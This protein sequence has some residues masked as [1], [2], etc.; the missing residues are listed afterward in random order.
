MEKYTI[1][2]TEDSSKYIDIYNKIKE[3][4]ECKE[5]LDGEKLPTIRI[6]SKYLKVNKITVINAY[7]KLSTEGYIYQVQG[8]GSYARR[9]EAVKNLKNEYKDI[10]NKIASG[11]LKD[12]IDFTGETTSTNFFKVETLREV[13]NEVLTRDGIDALTYND[14]LG[15]KSLRESINNNFWNGKNCLDNML[16]ISG[17]QQGIDIV[18]KALINI[19]E[20]VIVEKPTYSGALTV[21][22][23]RGANVLQVPIENDG[24]NIEYLEKLIK[25]YKVKCFYTM[26]Y[27]QNPTGVS[28]S[29][30]KKKKIIEL[31][32]KYNFYIIEDDYLS[33]LIYDDEIEYL[34]YRSLDSKRVI[35]IKSFSKI[36]LPGIRIGYLLAPTEFNEILHAS[37]VSTDISTSSLMQRALN[38]Y[39]TKG[40]WVDHIKCLNREY[41][42]R[43]NYV[44]KLIKERLNGLVT[45]HEPKGGLNLFLNINKNLNVTSKELFYKLKEK[46]TIITPGVIFFHNA[47]DGEWSFRLG[48]SQLDYKNIDKGINNIYEILKGR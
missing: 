37:K 20:A 14:S 30:K 19:N 28:C 44:V 11:E 23:L 33:E 47:K 40:Y 27:F 29:L 38:E 10:F 22:K 9:K 36:F 42:N 15:Y 24:V 18:A 25:K 13:F 5:I 6:L 43:Y 7:K 35:Y 48:F 21:L 39:I 1:K 45:F 4:I 2:F 34:P 3:L 31:A 12:F 26:S 46:N 32:Y 41:S 16:I 8:S 17:A